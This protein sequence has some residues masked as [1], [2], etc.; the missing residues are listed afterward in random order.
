M[1]EHSLIILYKQIMKKIVYLIIACVM[2]ITPLW[3]DTS[4]ATWT[5]DFNDGKADGWLL[6][7]QWE[8]NSNMLV[9]STRAITRIITPKLHFDAN[10]VFSFQAEKIKWCNDDAELFVNV[11]Y[12]TDRINWTNVQRIT[13]TRSQGSTEMTATPTTHQYV[14]PEA[15]DFYISIED[16]Y[17]LMDNFSGGTLVAVDH[18]IQV[19]NLVLPNEAVVNKPTQ[20][21]F[22][23]YN[24]A[25]QELAAEDYSISLVANG[26]VLKR[27][28]SEVVASSERK[29]FTLDY[30]PHTALNDA[31]VAIQV[32]VNNETI[33]SENVKWT[34][35]PEV[36][37]EIVMVGDASKVR[38]NADAVIDLSKAVS[39]VEVLYPASMLTL[40]AGSVINALQL[41]YQASD[42]Q[43][44]IASNVS[45]WLANESGTSIG[46][47][48]TDVSTMTSVMS[49]EA[50]NFVGNGK[51]TEDYMA[52]SFTSNFTYTGGDL[53]VVIQTETANPASGIKFG[54]NKGSDEE[55]STN[56]ISIIDS[57]ADIASLS[58]EKNEDKYDNP[59]YDPSSWTDPEFYY[60]KQTPV[61]RF[62][63]SKVSYSS[64]FVGDD[65]N[66]KSSTDAV[67]DLSKAVSRVETLYS[68]SQ[69]TVDANG[70][71][72][73]IELPYMSSQSDLSIVSNISIWIL[74]E[75]G[76]SI[77]ST[78]TD[79]S[80]M[81]Q[82]VNQKAV[83]FVGN[84]SYTDYDYISIEFAQDFVYT[85]TDLR[86]VIQ[87]ETAAPQSGMKF[88]INKGSDEESSTSTIS[89]IGDAVDVAS[90]VAEK[91]E[92]KYANPYFD[93]MDWYSPEYFYNKQT[94]VMR[95]LV[96]QTG[97]TVSGTI[98]DGAGQAIEG[99]TIEAL[100]AGDILY[101]TVTLSDGSYALPIIQKGLKYT[102]SAKKL[103]YT[104]YSE[105]LQ[106]NSNYTMNASLAYADLFEISLAV[107]G[108]TV[109]NEA[110]FMIGLTNAGLQEQLVSEY[111]LEIVIN[112]AAYA[113]SNET[114]QAGAHTDFSYLYTALTTDELTVVAH[115]KKNSSIV[116][117]VTKTFTP[118]VDIP[119][120]V[121]L[122]K[123]VD[124]S[125]HQG[126]CRI[127]EGQAHF[128]VYT[129]S[130]LRVVDQ[131]NVSFIDVNS[132]NKGVYVVIVRNENIE[133][134]FKII[135]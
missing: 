89:L 119:N 6:D 61:V 13:T 29:T 43:L 80:S 83:T 59:Y 110:T 60:N 79:V 111:E 26:N 71:V 82:V 31:D 114:L 7:S 99:V 41:A 72:A 48:F 108:L 84:G 66:I 65:S 85:G 120:G 51:Y 55:S 93:P 36:S 117:T 54:Y 129:M 15:G 46:S 95:L 106:L 42:D 3:A 5:E 25:P 4:P 112:D 131:E 57:A 1:L 133:K 125:Y 17:S 87:S 22:E 96:P 88:G 97:I 73:G 49:Q 62:E 2:A 11:S 53:R 44:T 21:A 20:I 70:K 23:L 86:V 32:S 122:S 64:V 27:F 77:G 104:T 8:V 45:I 39:R 9:G 107:T 116:A 68:A 63:V 92:N 37:N 123:A 47:S 109:N 121:D 56:T 10:A 100:A 126:I 118:T 94:P 115:V 40:D 98:L 28:V 127:S 16:G 74:N 33:D 135:R 81:T 38:T 91:N 124:I 67:I 75:T 128:S 102:I 35:A 34:V 78:F 50:T 69:I 18:D 52:L 132:L 113:V 76:N 105:K 30:T 14:V 90:L 24:I 12:S 19:S 103:G 58:A 134:I 130:G 101:S